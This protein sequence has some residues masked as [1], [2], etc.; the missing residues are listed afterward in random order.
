L[1]TALLTGLLLAGCTAAPEEIE[2]PP[3]GPDPLLVQ[4]EEAQSLIER[5]APEHLR[6]AVELLQAPA[7][8]H[9]EAQELL[10]FTLVVFE[11]LY[12]EL[13]E[14]DYIALTGLPY[15]GSHS[16]TL[17][18][19]L[20]AQA[21]AGG[22]VAGS[23][24]IGGPQF[25]DYIVPTLFIARL[26]VP[27]SKPT[28]PDLPDY[29]GLLER[30]EAQN[31]SSVLPPYLQGRIYELQGDF[32]QAARF[33]RSSAERAASFYPGRQSL[34]SLLLRQGR[35]ADA[36]DFLQQ[37]SSLF[38][39]DL[40]IRHSLA[41]AY[42]Q[43]E[44]LE[45]AAAEVAQILMQE[46]D[47]AE[48]ML[49][50]AQVLIAEGN[51]TQALRVLNLMLYR[52]ADNKDAYLLLARI[53]YEQ[54]KDPESALEVI[55]EAEGQFPSAAQFPELAGE[56]YLATGRDG[57]GLNKLQKALELEPGRVATLRLLLSNSIR[58]QRWL[59]GAIY[60]SEIL[61]QEQ[62]E[63]DLLQAIEIYKS[64]GDPAQ[65]LYYA[66]Q[67]YQGNPTEKNLVIYI[68]ALFADGQMEQA[69]A[70]V[71]QGLEQ[72]ES[73]AVHSTLLALKASTIAEQ[74]PE[75]ALALIREALMEYPNNYT[76]LV[77]IAE[78]YMKQRELRKASL[79][80]K[81][82]LALDPN[83]TALRIQLQ[84]IEKALGD[85]NTR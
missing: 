21:P 34:A 13:A 28:P 83:N 22:P 85:E 17:E 48:A 59:Q 57:E 30:A 15:T 24:G 80:I 11:L 53:H 49:L 25:Y 54:A 36:V 33:Y 6:E 39:E 64:L 16:H 7:Q 51:W 52:H 66:E 40:S 71:E 72:S 42:Y 43:S 81:Q 70:L 55:R 1:L 3:A 12:P 50:R 79:Y 23:P 31:S 78:L 67:L 37:L 65:V 68:R 77:Q 9:A 44:Q 75:Q 61:E 73:A 76:A 82:A 27:A 58:M 46:P 47:R 41:Q 84:G 14:S 56:I 69:I 20:A 60:L 38:P 62:S 63:E 19:A 5:G 32:E 10:S 18:R 74:S 4:I 26:E 2:E 35:A 8:S 29:L 45:A